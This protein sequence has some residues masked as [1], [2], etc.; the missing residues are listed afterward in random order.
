FHKA[1]RDGSGKGDVCPSPGETV[2]GV[3]YDIDDS[4][5]EILDR[6]EGLGSGYR[7]EDVV[8]TLAD[9]STLE[10]TTYIALDVDPSI[11]PYAWY[12]QHVLIGAREHGFPQDYIST[13]EVTT[14]HKDPDSGRRERELAI[15]A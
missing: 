12:L 9:G 4:E 3:V 8:V 13:I 14:T 1:S 7:Q 5:R 15:Y 2:I 11:K 10:A 6:I